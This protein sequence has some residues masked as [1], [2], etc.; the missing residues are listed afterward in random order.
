MAE[1]ELN[2]TERVRCGFYTGIGI[3]V[4][5]FS[6]GS[7]LLMPSKPMRDYARYLKEN[8]KGLIEIGLGKVL[9]NENLIEKGHRRLRDSG[10][11]YPPP[12]TPSK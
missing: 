1:R 9:L 12:E 5:P 7:S 8:H 4:Y 3:L 2:L 11:L 6:E 10:K